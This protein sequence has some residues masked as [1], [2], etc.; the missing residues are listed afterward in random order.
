MLLRVGLILVVLYLF[1]R[2]FERSNIWMPRRD[3]IATPDAAGLAY[4]DV[5]LQTADGLRLHGW[6]LPH[7]EA[8]AALLFCH[9]NAGNVSHRI[10]SLRQWHSLGLNVFL[11]DYRGY[12]R[13]AGR[14]TE[15]GTYQDALAAYNWLQGRGPDLP[16]VLFG[17]SL[18]A[19]VAIDLAARGKGAALIAESGFTSV[20]AIGQELFPILPVKWLVRTRY[21]SLAKIPQ[22]K[23]PVLVIHSR[24]DEIVPFHHGE[25]LFEAAPGPKQF[26]E[27]RGGHNDGYVLSETE[28]LRGIQAFLDYSM[29]KRNISPQGIKIQ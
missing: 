22:V 6:Y 13:S 14:P 24:E 27:I 4:E 26:L 2:W 20:P 11:F 7:A 15:E 25:A 9:G 3:F 28:Y 1:F 21:D 19:A 17:R 18:G 10:E 8:S 23:I 5:S 12:G 29:K 16:I